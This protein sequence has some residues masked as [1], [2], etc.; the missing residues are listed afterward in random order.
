M[1]KGYSQCG[2]DRVIYLHVH[3]DEPFSF[4]KLIQRE[5]N[6]CQNAFKTFPQL[7]S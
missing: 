2:E 5:S 7:A 1:F 6:S 3:T 4:A